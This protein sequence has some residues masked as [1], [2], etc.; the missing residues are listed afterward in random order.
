[1]EQPKAMFSQ[2][3]ESRSKEEHFAKHEE[4]RKLLE[5]PSDRALQGEQEALSKLSE[6]EFHTRTL[7]EAKK[8]NTLRSKIRNILVGKESRR[9]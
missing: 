4:D 5:I 7:L 2:E 1:M 6:A 3:R 9:S 8:S